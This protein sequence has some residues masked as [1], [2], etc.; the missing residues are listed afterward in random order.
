MAPFS[1]RLVIALVLSCIGISAPLRA[2]V[3]QDVQESKEFVSPIKKGARELA[4]LGGVGIAHE[5]WDGVGD[6]QFYVVGVRVG[7]VVSGTRGPGFLRGNLEVAGEFLPVFLVDQ[8]TTS[9]G[10]SATFV[11]RH[12]FAPDSRWRP[13]G[14][15]GFGVLGTTDEVPEGQTKLNFTP[16][17]GLGISYASSERFVFYFDYR[18]HHISNGGRKQPN[19]G[20]NSSALQFSVSVLRW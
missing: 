4:I 12:F 10:A 9:Y 15:V 13:Y 8:G 5:I 17:I 18:I 16:Q 11:A 19:P 20:I 6:T 14:V 2:D 3:G 1:R 7:R